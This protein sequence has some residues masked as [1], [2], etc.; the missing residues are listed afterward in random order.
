MDREKLH[1]WI[2]RPVCESCQSEHNIEPY[3]MDGRED[4]VMLCDACYD[5]IM[6][7]Q[8]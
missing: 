5:A 6:T 4:G 2:R 1:E 8:E 3:R 7:E